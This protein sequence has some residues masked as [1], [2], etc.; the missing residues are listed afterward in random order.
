MSSPPFVKVSEHKA[1]S[2]ER[3]LSGIQSASETTNRSSTLVS[4]LLT[5]WPPGPP[6][7]EKRIVSFSL[8]MMI[9]AL[10]MWPR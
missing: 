6:E 2:L 4:T 1:T 10:G 9:G 8:G 3:M 7:R 5:F